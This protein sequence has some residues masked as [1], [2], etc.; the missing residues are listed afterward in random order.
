MVS[1]T[2]TF[3]SKVTILLEDTRVQLD[4]KKM[5]RKYMLGVMPYSLRKRMTTVMESGTDKEKVAITNL[6]VWKALLRK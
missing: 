3:L 2:T 6:K 1:R 4:E 5:I